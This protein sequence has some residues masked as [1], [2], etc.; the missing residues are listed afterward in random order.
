MTALSH[1]VGERRAE[2]ADLQARMASMQDQLVAA[3]VTLSHS[4]SRSLSLARSL[5]LSLS[6]PLSPTR[7]SPQVFT[8]KSWYPR[9]GVSDTRFRVSKAERRLQKAAGRRKGEGA[10]WPCGDPSGGGGARHER[11]SH[12]HIPCR[13]TSL[14]RKTFRQGWTGPRWKPSWRTPARCTYSSRSRTFDPKPETRNPKSKTRKP[15]NPQ[16]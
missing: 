9:S 12:V 1:Q 4:L 15:L 11:G 3:G 14:M 2:A 7:L 6:R 8:P 5:S 13:G 10:P 16:P